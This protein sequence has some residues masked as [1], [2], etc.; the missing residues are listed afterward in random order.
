MLLRAFVTQND[1][2]A[3]TAIVKR[4]GPLVSAIC[5]RVLHNLHDAEDAFQATFILLARNAI[6][7]RKQESLA[8]WLHGVAYRMAK[9][10]KRAAERRRRHEGEAK[11]MCETSPRWDTAWQEVQ[12]ILDEEIQRLPEI[13]RTAFVLCCLENRSRAEAAQAVGIKEATLRSRLAKARELLQQALARRGVALS[14]VLAAAALAPDA[15]SATVPSTVISATVKAATQIAASDGRATGIIAAHV[16]ALVKGTQT[17]M[18][19][20]KL[21]KVTLLLLTLTAGI[22]IGLRVFSQPQTQAPAAPSPER[23]AT[24]QKATD[25]EIVVRGRVLDPDGKPFAG[26]KLYLH[27]FSPK[28]MRYPVRAT[29]GIDGRF[30]FTFFQSELDK[31]VSDSPWSQVLAT[32]PGYGFK[33]A[34]VGERGKEAELTLQLVRDVSIRG[35]VF[36][37]D[38]KPVPG[39]KV[40][41]RDIHAFAEESLAEELADLRKG[42]F[43][44][45]P[46][47]SWSGPL[48]GQPK[49]VTSGADGRFRLTGVGRERMVVLQIE[50]PAIHYTTIDVM[51]RAAEKIVISNPHRPRTIYSASFDYLAALSRSVRGVVREKESGKPVAGIAISSFATTHTTRT[52]REGRYELLGCL[53]ANE[54]NVNVAPGEGQPYFRSSFHFL[55]TPGLTPLTGD[56]ELVRGIPLRG[57]LTDK[58]TGKPIPNAGIEYHPLYPSPYGRGGVSSTART[59]RDGSFALA[60]Q[61]GPGVLGATALEQAA[62]MAARIMPQEMKEFFKDS[63]NWSDVGNSE[64]SLLV[65]AGDN[66]AQGMVQ[67]NYNVLVLIDPAEKAREIKQDLTLRPAR[68]LKGQVV[69]PD[70]QPLAGTSAYGLSPN[71]VF[72]PQTLTR[73]AFTVTGLHP[74]RSRQILFYHDEKKLGAFKEITPDER[75]PLTIQLQPCASA[76]GRLVD[77]DGQPVAGVFLHFNR[78]GLIGPGGPEAKTDKEGRFRTEGLVAGQKYWLTL[79]NRPFSRIRA[80]VIVVKPAEKKDLGDVTVEADR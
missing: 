43:G 66:A 72:L 55:D 3:F 79:A 14:A 26:A 25:K 70:C 34:S 27:Y 71:H 32:A 5:R 23:T 75:E 65:S 24:P 57:R 50:E 67:E 29:S 51:T 77:R 45:R 61:P 49:E 59:G 41:L 1:Q 6:S 54:Y 7:I 47:K 80:K 78:L 30:A 56:I 36:D 11:L 37:P 22:G 17:A 20:T 38:G 42:G 13:Y 58:T 48:P 62:Y 16:A 40:R 39:A 73:N 31:T 68:T 53:K 35:R 44:I 74:Q 15:N 8:G 46:V 21:K 18:F 2:D 10:A 60:V 12:T 9:N 64:M 63:K 19:S 76:S 69:G 52:N 4:Y 28:E 33:V